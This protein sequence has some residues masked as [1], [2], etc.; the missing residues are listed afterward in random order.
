MN[1][2]NNLLKIMDSKKITQKKL[3]DAITISTSTLNNWLKLHR[4]I[5]SE[6]IIPICEFLDISPD[7]LL[8][9]KEKSPPSDLADDEQLLLKYYRK[10]YTL[11]KGIIIGR[12]EALAG[13]ELTDDTVQRHKNNTIYIDMFSLPVSAGSGVYLDSSD[14]HM[15]E[16]ESN[17]LTQQ[18][19][20]ALTISG[21]SMQPKYYD[22]DVVLIESQP[23]VGIGEIGI[24]IYENEGYIK[25][26]GGDKLISLNPKYP[27][28]L[29]KD[30]DSFYCKGKVIG[31]L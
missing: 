25:K 26:F 4:S 21:D 30:I 28:I 10:L 16:V 24:F 8:T 6:Y 23:S 19:N 13:V 12:A 29:I 2:N 9:G 18:A 22:G 20:F 27:D 7:Y 1:I 15:I 5:P 3:S 14:K 17:C 31:K 11:Q